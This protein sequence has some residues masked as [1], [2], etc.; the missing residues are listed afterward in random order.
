MRRYRDLTLSYAD[1]AGAVRAR[2]ARAAAVFGLNDDFRALG[3]AVEPLV[4]P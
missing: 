3:F 4:A 2:E 1:A